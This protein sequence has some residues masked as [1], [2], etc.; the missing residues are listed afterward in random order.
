MLSGLFRLFLSDQCQSLTRFVNF[1]AFVKYAVAARDW[2]QAA[3]NATFEMKIGRCTEFCSMARLLWWTFLELHG[4]QF[5]A[6][7][8]VSVKCRIRKKALGWRWVVSTFEKKKS[9]QGVCRFWKVLTSTEFIF[10]QHHQTYIESMSLLLATKLGSP[11]SHNGHIL[12]LAK[13]LME[14][15]E[16]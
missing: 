1:I 3:Q 11:L 14:F 16:M 6:I 12:I 2:S 15:N 10:V 13:I 8:W 9:M 5:A 4:C 7:L